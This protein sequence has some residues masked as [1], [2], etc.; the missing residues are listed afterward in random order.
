MYGCVPNLPSI[1]LP[2]KDALV[3]SYVDTKGHEIIEKYIKSGI[4]V[5]GIIPVN[6]KKIDQ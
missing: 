1:T 2:G 6:Y 4:L 3:F 5:E